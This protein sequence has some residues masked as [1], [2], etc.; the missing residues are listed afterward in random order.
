MEVVEV[1]EM[2]EMVEMV[3]WAVNGGVEEVMGFV[4]GFVG[5][6]VAADEET[7]P[8]LDCAVMRP[9][10]AAVVDVRVVVAV[11]VATAAG[12]LLLVLV[13][14]AVVA[15][16][17]VWVLLRG[18]RAVGSSF[19]DDGGAVGVLSLLSGPE[20]LVGCTSVL[21]VVMSVV[22][23]VVTGGSGCVVV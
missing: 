18:E 16:G 4:L 5:F 2:V 14:V 22:V 10:G 12:C 13:L 15:V 17:G 1:V 8:P 20:A 11:A 21:V 7:L 9:A 3:G 19:P 6:A 23:G